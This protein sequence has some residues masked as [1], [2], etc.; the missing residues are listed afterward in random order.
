MKDAMIEALEEIENGMCRMVNG[1]IDQCP[2]RRKENDYENQ[3]YNYDG[4]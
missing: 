2:I 4:K 3:N 1:I